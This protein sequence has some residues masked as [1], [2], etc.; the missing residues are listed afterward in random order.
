V[1]RGKGFAFLSFGADD[2]INWSF[3]FSDKY[4][5]VVLT[6]A[7][8]AEMLGLSGTPG[9]NRLTFGELLDLVAA[10]N[11]SE[12]PDKLVAC[13]ALVESSG[14]PSAQNPNSSA[15]G[16]MQMTAP[17]ISSYVL[18]WYSDNPS[19]AG[20]TAQSLYAQQ[21]DPQISIM[22]GSAYLQMLAYDR[23]NFGIP[24]A[25]AHYHYGPGSRN[26]ARSYIRK[27]TKCAK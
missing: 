10:N 19:F 1:I 5:G 18:P 27:I 25:L 17:T 8:L 11:M 24:A 21:V 13:V 16:L 3:S 2:T 26:P 15:L 12:L 22:T 9:T 6:N 23:W 20:F 4:K 14:D 7:A